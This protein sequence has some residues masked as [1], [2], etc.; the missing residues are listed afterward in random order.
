MP[1]M[2]NKRCTTSADFSV[3]TP[4]R[5]ASRC[6]RLDVHRRRIEIADF[7]QIQELLVDQLGFQADLRQRAER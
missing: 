5:T 7:A 1:P 4:K 2:R 3:A 6:S